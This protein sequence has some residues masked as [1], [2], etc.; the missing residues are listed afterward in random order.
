MLDILTTG[1]HGDQLYLP[2]LKNPPRRMARVT[3]YT[4]MNILFGYYN[5]IIILLERCLKGGGSLFFTLWQVHWSEHSSIS[6]VKWG[7]WFTFLFKIIATLRVYIYKK[8]N[9]W[10]SKVYH[11]M[12][13]LDLYFC[14]QY[15]LFKIKNI[16]YNIY[17]GC[18]NAPF[19]LT[20]KR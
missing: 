8:Y 19:F 10:K 13:N 3:I 18:K 20:P 11:L 5:P 1:P 9:I 2:D 15:I 4:I 12:L 17:Q 7:N 14:I 16:S 6:S